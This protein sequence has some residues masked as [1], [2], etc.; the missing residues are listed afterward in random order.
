M[1]RIYKPPPPPPRFS[2]P[3]QIPSPPP[4]H[5]HQAAA[6]PCVPADPFVAADPSLP[7]ISLL[8]R[9]QPGVVLRPAA[10]ETKQESSKD[11]SRGIILILF[12][13]F[14][15]SHRG[16][17]SIALTGARA[18]SKLAKPDPSQLGFFLW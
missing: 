18:A 17:V 7:S 10:A 16:S 13:K 5:S 12:E 6:D 11:D 1:A 2:S 8:H 3:Q 15:F 4:S 9:R 14:G